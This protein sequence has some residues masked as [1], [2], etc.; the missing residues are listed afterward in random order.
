MVNL[1]AIAGCYVVVGLFSRL[2]HKVQF[3]VK[4]INMALITVVSA[5]V[6]I[7]CA[8]VLMLMG[9]RSSLNWLTGRVFYGLSTVMLGVNVV[10]ENPEILD[11]TKPCIMI[12]NHQSVIDLIWLGASFPR[13]AV[14]LAKKVSV[15]FFPEGTRGT[16]KD[17]PDMLQFKVGAF[18]LAKLAKVP[19][20][21]VVVSDFHN[22]ID[23]KRW[24]FPGGTIKLRVLPPIDLSNVDEDKLGPTISE[25]RETMLKNLIEISPERTSH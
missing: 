2:N 13:S 22:I 15:F 10:I 3:V 11:K 18:L 17:G 23:S 24:W 16:H 4:V 21:P 8:P 20:V 6:S 9:Q 25:I 1:Y 19:I 14:I 12:G 5:T 7:S